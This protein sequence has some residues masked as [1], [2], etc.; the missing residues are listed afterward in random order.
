MVS[1]PK[2]F[3]LHIPA[4]TFTYSVALIDFLH[5][6]VH[7]NFASA[8]NNSI[9]GGSECWMGAIIVN[10]FSDGGMRLVCDTNRVVCVIRR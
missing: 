10:Y 5:T 9:V 2:L 4:L 7:Y 3:S 8:T 6:T 1:A